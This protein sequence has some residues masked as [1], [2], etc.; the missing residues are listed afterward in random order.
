MVAEQSVGLSITSMKICVYGLWH[1]GT[2]TAACMAE[3]LKD[4]R[5]GRES[6][7]GLHDAFATL[8]IVEQINQC[9]SN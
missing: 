6:V 7:Q 8:K 3:F 2:V 4:I 9:C 5:L 1:L